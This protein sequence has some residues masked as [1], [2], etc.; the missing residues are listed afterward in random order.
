ME[1]NVD[2]FLDENVVKFC[3]NL[4]INFMIKDG[5]TKWLIRY[6]LK[7]YLPVEILWNKKHVGLNAPANIWFRKDLKKDLQQTINDIIKEKTSQ[8][9][10]QINSKIFL[11]NIF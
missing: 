3:W 4:P 9:L 8:S 1:L 11:K 6:S 2:Q 10:T 5:Y 7:D